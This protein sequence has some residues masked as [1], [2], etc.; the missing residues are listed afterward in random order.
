MIGE[1]LDIL[2]HRSK[3]KYFKKGGSD[4]ISSLPASDEDEFAAVMARG[5]NGLLGFNVSPAARSILNALLCE[6]YCLD[7]PD[8]IFHPG[9]RPEGGMPDYFFKDKGGAFNGLLVE[10][11]RYVLSLKKYNIISRHKHIEVPLPSMLAEFMRDGGRLENELYKH[12][13]S[14]CEYF[15]IL[16]H[17]E[18]HGWGAFDLISHDID[19]FL[20]RLERLVGDHG[21][22]VFIENMRD[23]PCW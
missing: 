7:G 18:E 8:T 5:T 10:H 23:M 3:F 22:L 13:L 12:L 15:G 1:M 20:N 14:S 6:C 21:R 11:E 9:E 17:S 19:Y 16:Q 2:V 4:L